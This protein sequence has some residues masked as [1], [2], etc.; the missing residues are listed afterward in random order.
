MRW[1]PLSRPRIGGNKIEGTGGLTRLKYEVNTKSL[2]RLTNTYLGK[3]ILVT[4]RE[5]WSEEKIILAYRSQHLIEDVFEEMKNRRI[6][7]GWPMHHWTD[8]TDSTDSTIRVH[9]LY[10]T[11][12]MLLRGLLLR[13]VRRAGI[14][15]SMKRLLRELEDIREVINVYPRKQGRRAA[16]QQTV[17]SKRSELQN[18][19]LSISALHD[20]GKGVLG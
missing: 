13:R 10:R 5:Q 7:S 20:P 1:T 15:I 17:L 3:N 8:S 6:G 12:A 2:D 11:I 19:P 16:R 14:D 18:R 4:D 9:G